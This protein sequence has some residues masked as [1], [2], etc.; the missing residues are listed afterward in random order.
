MKYLFIYLFINSLSV[1]AQ[2]I[3]V[4]SEQ[5]KQP[6]SFSKIRYVSKNSLYRGGG[7]YTN[8]IGK[9]D[10]NIDSDIDSLE[11]TNE[12]NLLKIPSKN[13]PQKIYLNE[14]INSDI[15]FLTKDTFNLLKK[16]INF[17]QDSTT[18]LKEIIITNKK[19]PTKYLGYFLE[20]TRN[21]HVFFSG[22]EITTLIKN[23]YNIDKNIKTICFIVYTY[24][25][26]LDAYFKI[27]LYKNENDKP[28]KLHTK[29]NDN[30]F[31]L[32]KNKS[33]KIK[34]DI[35]NLEIKLPK[36]G[37]FIG[38]EFMGLIDEKTN[39]IIPKN[40][41]DGEKHVNN[42]IGIK[43]IKAAKTTYSYQRRKF[44]NLDKGIYS[45]DWYDYSKIYQDLDKTTKNIFYTPAIG[46]EVYE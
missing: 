33:K 40:I 46:I 1:F 13:L 19:I 29:N 22:G 5:T 8:I 41:M 4:L 10:I 32:K 7:V 30:I 24:K 2:E 38:L 26:N 25:Q 21:G 11:I 20:K 15:F 14:Y 6:L 12:E 34:I 28:Q 31:I 23:P 43:Y 3:Q 45:K 36:E 27:N 9:A 18:Y 37:L 17:S 42:I 44:S 16:N 39:K 35:Q